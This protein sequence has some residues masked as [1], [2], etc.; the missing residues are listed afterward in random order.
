TATISSSPHPWDQLVPNPFSVFLVAWQLTLQGLV[1]PLRP[2]DQ[3]QAGKASRNQRPQGTQ[4]QGR[5]HGKEYTADVTGVT[6]EGV[7][8]G[9]DDLLA[10][11]CLDADGHLKE[12]VHGFRPGNEAQ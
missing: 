9:V 11:I 8:A 3:Q 2:Q 1:L 4:A 5:A 6:H 12:L 10:P 7:G